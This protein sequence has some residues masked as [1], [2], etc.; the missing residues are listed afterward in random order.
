MIYN[1][2]ASTGCNVSRLG[3]GTVKFGRNQGVKYPEDFSLPDDKTISTL[4]ALASEFGVNLL[5]TAPAYGSSEARLGKLLGS[6]RQNWLISTKVGESFNDGIS[7]FDFSP[8]A[9]E[10]SVYRSLKLLATDYLDIVL[11]HSDGDDERIIKELD[12]LETLD[13]FKTKGLIRCFGVST[14]TTQG[15]MLAIE[16]SDLA[17]VSYSLANR[18]EQ[19]VLDHALHLH[20]GI[21]IKKALDSGQR[22]AHKSHSEWIEDSLRFVFK[23][24]AVTSVILGTISPDHL[25]ENL[26]LTERIQANDGG[27]KEPS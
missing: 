24:P 25:R 11:V 18:R 14:K 5:D 20:K 4:L 3:L 22:P 6:T 16:Q 19:S 12:T 27:T 13:K 7:T 15:G 1:E 23:H 9:V 26:L 17:M 10:Q 21:F 2:I 8:V